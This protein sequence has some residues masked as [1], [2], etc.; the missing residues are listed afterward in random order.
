MFRVQIFSI[1][2][3]IKE[4]YRTNL[5]SYSIFS[6][7]QMKVAEDMNEYPERFVKWEVAGYNEIMNSEE[8]SDVITQVRR[9]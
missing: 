5:E 3:K 9:F 4:L 2:N 6:F 7:L 1:L 8:L